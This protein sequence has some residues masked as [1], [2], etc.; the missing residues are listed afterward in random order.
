MHLV[1]NKV[2]APAVQSHALMA[3]YSGTSLGTLTPV[4]SFSSEEGTIV[5]KAQSNLTYYI[6]IDGFDAG[7]GAETANFTLTWG[8]NK[9]SRMADIDGDGNADQSVYR[10]TT[11]TWYSLGSVDNTLR[12]GQW[13][14]N[15]DKP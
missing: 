2:G 13:G 5:F 12:A 15:G 6:A 1:N 11:G 8:L 3:L 7:Q 9:S 10:P 14:T 4:Q